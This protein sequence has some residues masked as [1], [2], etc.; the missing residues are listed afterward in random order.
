MKEKGHF[1]NRKKEEEERERERG[2][3]ACSSLQATERAGGKRERDER[4]REG[5]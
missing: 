2:D 5:T 1:S 3:T 4:E